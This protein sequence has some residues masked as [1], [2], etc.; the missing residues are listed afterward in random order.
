V[1][2]L[3][4]L[5]TWPTAPVRGAFWVAEQVASEADRRL[6]DEGNIR[7]ELMQLELEAGEGRISD[8]EREEREEILL[9]RLAVARERARATVDAE[10]LEAEED[11]QDD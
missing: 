10:A 11:A 7:R 8:A 9:E 1:G 6:Y 2:L 4:G 3:K 5:V